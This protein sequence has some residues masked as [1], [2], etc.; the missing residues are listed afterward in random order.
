VIGWLNWGIQRAAD[1]LAG[2]LAHLPTSPLRLDSTTWNGVHGV[3][4]WASWL[5]PIHEAVLL[6]LAIVAA[7]IAWLFVRWGLH[8]LKFASS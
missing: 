5:L 8:W 2:I 3:M 7:Y 6:S 4:G 1:S